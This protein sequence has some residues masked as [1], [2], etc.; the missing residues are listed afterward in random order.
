M[1]SGWRKLWSSFVPERDF[2]GLETAASAA[3]VKDTAIV[4]EIVS[5]GKSM[6][7]EVD[8]EGIE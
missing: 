6:G 4:E 2:E 5:M 8:S 7:M 3:D 1:N